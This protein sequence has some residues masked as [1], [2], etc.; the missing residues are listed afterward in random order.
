MLS[1]F[2]T[3]LLNLAWLVSD[4]L[5]L[6]HILQLVLLLSATYYYYFFLIHVISNS[7][8]S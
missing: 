4:L 1:H 6:D 8:S 2:K 5:Y 7:V 3:I